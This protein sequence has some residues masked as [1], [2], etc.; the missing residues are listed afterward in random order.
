MVSTDNSEVPDYAG[1]LRFDGKN[2]IVVGAGQGMGRQTS[3][4]LKQCGATLVTADL[5]DARAKEIAEEVGAT[6]WVGDATQRDEV[7]RLVR[8]ASSALGGRID[9]FVD[10]IG[11]ARFEEILDLS[12]D[13]FDW[14][15]DI[16]LRHAYL[17]TQLVGRHMRETGGGGSM[18]F[19]ASVSALSAAPRHAAYGAMK[20][21]LIAWVKTAAVELAPHG[22]R[23]NAVAPGAILTPR[24]EAVF[25]EDQIR[26]NAADAPL[27][28][29]GSP[30]DIASAAL[31]LSSDLAQYITGQTVIVDGG[32]TSKF[33]FGSTL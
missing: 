6:P 7:E 30:S 15:V 11:M 27:N 19:V 9:G 31:F 3:H 20:A 33:P 17:L 22:I 26:T 10:I 21:G 4:A 18:V 2:F 25:T 5:E 12:D 23:A 14:E 32:V 8:D 29:M 1:R 28:R 16:C 13:T 24:M